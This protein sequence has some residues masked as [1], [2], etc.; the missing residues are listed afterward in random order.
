VAAHPP[1]SRF[2]HGVACGRDRRTD[3]AFDKGQFLSP[4]HHDQPYYFVDGRQVC[5]IW[6]PLDPV[7]LETAV[8]FVRGSHNWGRWYAPRY[9]VDGKDYYD[10]AGAGFESM[11]DI[12]AEPARFQLLSWEM[13]PGDCIVFHALTIHGAPGNPSLQNR[14]CAYATRWMGD[15][16]RFGERKGLISPQI[17]GHGLAPGDPMDCEMFPIVWREGSGSGQ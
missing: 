16:A 1:I 13:A 9:F 11:P 2:R 8:K 10:A 6:M 5:S 4:W 14:R 3:D 7:P 15:D 17:D 12:E